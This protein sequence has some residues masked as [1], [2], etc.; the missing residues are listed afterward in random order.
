MT[1]TRPG[2]SAVRPH[3]SVP[4]HRTPP[5]LPARRPPP[6]RS[7]AG[8]SASPPSPA[9]RP[10]AVALRSA[11]RPR[12]VH[13]PRCSASAKRGPPAPA[14]RGRSR[15]AAPAAG[16]PNRPRRATGGCPRESAE[17]R[18]HVPPDLPAHL[19]RSSTPQ[20]ILLPEGVTS[21]SKKREQTSCSTGSSFAMT[22]SRWLATIC[23]APPSRCRVLARS[24]RERAFLSS[25]H[26]RVITSCRNG[27][28]IRVVSSPVA[29]DPRRRIA[30]AIPAR[31]GPAT[32]PT[33]RVRPRSAWARHFPERSRVENVQGFP[34][35]LLGIGGAEML[36]P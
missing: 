7:T 15:S 16:R 28:S 6:G 11:A 9:P 2:P 35:R 25:S 27:A 26:R 18:G 22:L 8:A 30:P 23:C 1:G 24:V 33:G 5:R 20:A 14:R 17:R 32:G 31:Y 12:R 36:Q 3:P 21:R 4:R 29:P 34:D 19:V 13:R 10:A